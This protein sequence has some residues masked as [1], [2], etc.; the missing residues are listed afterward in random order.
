MSQL[1]AHCV[2]VYKFLSSVQLEQYVCGCFKSGP[3]LELFLVSEGWSLYIDIDVVIKQVSSRTRSLISCL[4]DPEAM[5]KAT[6]AAGEIANV[7]FRD[8]IRSQRTLYKSFL[9]YI[10]LPAVRLLLTII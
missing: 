2:L 5:G 10:T 7:R 6:H 1:D 4:T 9:H 3:K 8:L